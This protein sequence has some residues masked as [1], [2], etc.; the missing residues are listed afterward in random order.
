M[1]NNDFF[2]YST[3]AGSVTDVGGTD[4]TGAT[5]KLKDGDNTIRE[6][7]AQ[8]KRYTSDAAAVNTV[9]GT[10]D[11]VTLTTARTI[12][13][14]ATGL[15]LRF[16]AGAANTTAA[17]LTVNALAAKAIRK[18]SGGT[19][20]AL[21][22]GDLAAGETYTVI[23]RASA[24]SAAGAW[25]IVGAAAVAAAT[26]SAFG[27]VKLGTL[28]QTIAQTPSGLVPTIENLFFPTGHL[29]GCTLSNNGGTPASKIDIAVG[30]CRDGSDTQNIICAAMTA[31]D[32]A[33][34]WAAGSS[35][36]IRYSGAAIANGTYHIYAVAKALGASQDYYAHPSGSTDAT[37]LTHLQAE[38]GGSAYL[39]VRRIGSI[40]RSGGS[41]LGFTQ[42]GDEFLLTQP[43]QD[44]S[45][46][47]LGTTAVLYTLTVPVGIKVNI[48]A[49]FCVIVSGTNYGVLLTSP[50]ETDT[51]AA[52]NTMSTITGISNTYGQAQP[53]IRTNTSGQI[54]AR[55]STASTQIVNVTHGWVDTRGR[56][57]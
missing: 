43:V 30:T 2:D 25:V 12:A 49:E 46:S 22:A 18:I 51:A 55:S 40:I 35:A 47:T 7:A 57:N 6:L 39:Y 15:M 31:K 5:G 11:A 14:L 8:S 41:I 24:N 16:I 36:G 20:V 19:D 37:V 1:A 53:R 33:S 34:N 17:T 3:A 54:R 9:G 27:T 38:T 10:G 28:A 42:I 52:G 21:A 23:Y 26:T 13:A 29:W 56:A 4:I 45:S 50:D 48:L 32:L 44:V